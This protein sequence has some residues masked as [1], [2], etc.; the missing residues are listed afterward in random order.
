MTQVINESVEDTLHIPAAFLLMRDSDWSDEEGSDSL[1][2]KHLLV[3]IRCVNVSAHRDQAKTDVSALDSL[4][5]KLFVFVWSKEINNASVVSSLLQRCMLVD[6]ITALTSDLRGWDWW[7]R[8]SSSP[9]TADGR[10]CPC[11]ISLWSLIIMPLCCVEIWRITPTVRC[12]LWMHPLQ[13][14]WHY[15]FSLPV[16]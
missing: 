6:M 11:L 14:S 8:L 15:T 3:L 2:Q 4:S 10:L 1:Q 16:L 9:V 12:C 13:Y 5:D 7:I